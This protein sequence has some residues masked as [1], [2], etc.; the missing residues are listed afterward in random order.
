MWTKRSWSTN[1]MMRA[2]GLWCSGE[3]NKK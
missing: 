2:I 1:T 3:E